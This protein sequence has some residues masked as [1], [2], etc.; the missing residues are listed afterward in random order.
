MARL[1]TLAISIASGRVGYALFDGNELIDWGI[2]SRATKTSTVLVGFVQELINQLKPDVSVSLKP[3]TESRKGTRTRKLIQAVA[4]L[5]EHNYV[6]NVTVERPRPYA[7]GF[8]EASAITKRYPELLGYKPPRRR[9]LFD[10]E[11]RGTVLFEAVLLA[12]HV[13]F[14]GPE[15]L[16]AALG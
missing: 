4:D 10:P 1:K 15:T 3:D 8:E 11:L 2:A 12:E 14:G 6:L 13:I 7:N 16:A 9:R 5:A